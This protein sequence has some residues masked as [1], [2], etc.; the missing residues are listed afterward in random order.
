MTVTGIPAVTLSRGEITWES[1]QIKAARGRGKY[2]P[3]PCFPPYWHA[4]MLRNA[5]ATP[6]RVPRG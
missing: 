6:S 4:Q 3:R 2:I 1:G 5:R